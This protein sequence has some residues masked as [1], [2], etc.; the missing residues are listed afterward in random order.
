[1][2]T[3]TDG[4]LPADALENARVGVSVS[5][6]PDLLRLGLLEDHFRLTLAELVR[7]VVVSSGKLMYGGHLDPT[8]YTA[9]IIDELQ[10]YA[11]RDQPFTVCLAWSEHRRL[12]LSAIANATR[13]L[14]L[15]G[16]IVFLDLDGNEVDP[17]QGRGNDPPSAVSSDDVR[18]GLTSLRRWMTTHAN[19]RILIGG[20]RHDF[21]GSLP[22][23][24]EE[25]LMAIEAQQPLYLVGGFGGVTWDIIRALRI[26]EGGWLPPLEEAPPEDERLRIGREQ[27]ES[28]SR[29]HN[30]RG[31]QNGLNP[32]ENLRLAATHRPSD[33]AALVSLGLGRIFQR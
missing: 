29:S 26:D 8:G 30:W 15:H 24:M 20:K 1:M 33:I 14:G 4:L 10:R 31:L 3:G 2:V 22:G 13:E 16:R 32:E 9:L 7:T 25:A 21:Q 28:A 23:L 6:S 18:R 19:G 17:M 5:E 12:A 27:L 11:R